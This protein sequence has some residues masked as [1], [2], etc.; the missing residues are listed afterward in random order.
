M[1][2]RSPTPAVSRQR[3]H[4]L[5]VGALAQVVDL[6][7]APGVHKGSWHRPILTHAQVLGADLIAQMEELGVVANIQP[8]FT[9]TDAA[10]AR[11]R[12]RPTALAHAY[13]WNDGIIALNQFHGVYKDAAG[14]LATVLNTDLPGVPLVIYNPLSIEREDVVE[15]FIPAELQQARAITAV[16]A[17]GK[18]LPTQLTTGWDGKRRVLF[19][20]KVPP[21]G[22]AVCRPAAHLGGGM[23][24][25]CLRLSVTAQHT[26][27]GAA[28]ARRLPCTIT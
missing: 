4:Q 24:P 7:L 11:R 3:L 15:A 14:S 5:P 9:L 10:W 22:A 6:Q 20:A 19:L 26:S 16:D 2:E 1:G 21:V 12:L 17:D 13:A 28:S 8:Q 18:S 27:H 25:A 23:M